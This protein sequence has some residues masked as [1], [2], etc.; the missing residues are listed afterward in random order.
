MLHILKLYAAES[1]KPVDKITF[2]VESA[3][4]LITD[5]AIQPNYWRIYILMT[6]KKYLKFHLL[7][8]PQK[9]YVTIFE[10]A[11]TWIGWFWNSSQYHRP[12][13]YQNSQGYKKNSKICR[14]KQL[15]QDMREQTNKF[16]LSQGSCSSPFRSIASLHSFL[17]THWRLLQWLTKIY[18]LPESQLSM[19]VFNFQTHLLI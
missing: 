18:H 3:K 6:S 19:C 9:Y 2:G 12:K 8:F 4:H 11:A 5:S 1:L 14:P 13:K 15:L 17:P 10:S 16:H 7:K